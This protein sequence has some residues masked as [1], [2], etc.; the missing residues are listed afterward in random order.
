MAVFTEVSE[1]EAGALLR[2][3]RLGELRSLR[4]I[5]A[6]SRTPT[7]SSPPKTWSASASTC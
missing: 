2:A 3:L 5:R 4:G 1:A 7:T 6:A